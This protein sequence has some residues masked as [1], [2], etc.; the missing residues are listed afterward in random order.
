MKTE[1]IV[2]TA[3]NIARLGDHKHRTGA[4]IF[5]GDKIISVGHNSIL[6]SI[7]KLHPRFRRWPGS[8]HAEVAAIINARR[9]LKGYDILIVRINRI[10][11]L[12]YAKPCSNCMKYIEY[13]GIDKV[14]YS[15]NEGT[16]EEYNEKN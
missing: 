2:N 8:I 9:K 10:E 1:R 14:Y 3:L 5:K 12:M 15:T 6:K 13:V 11:K 16:I 4:V 7:R